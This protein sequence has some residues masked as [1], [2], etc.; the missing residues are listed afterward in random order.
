MSKKYYA[1]YRPV[2]GRI[3]DVGDNVMFKINNEWTEPCDFDSFLGSGIQE[4]AGGVLYL[5]SKDIQVG[6]KVIHNNP[7]NQVKYGSELTIKEI[8]PSGCYSVEEGG[9][10]VNEELIKYVYEIS[11]K[12]IWIK[13][14]DEFDEED[15]EISK[16]PM[17]PKCCAISND[18]FC[19]HEIECEIDKKRTL[20]FIKGPCGHFH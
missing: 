9:V 3:N 17:C 5:C 1:K 8:L 20:V 18:G 10:Y 16:Y 14:G 12:S 19:P 4:V 7:I 11:P 15:I 2:S 13:Q 6:D